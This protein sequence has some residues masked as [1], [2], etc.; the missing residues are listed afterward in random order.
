MILTT[1]ERARKIEQEISVT[2][3]HIER[4]KRILSLASHDNKTQYE[5]KLNN[6]IFELEKRL[7]KYC[8]M[9]RDALELVN[10]LTGEERAVIERYYILAQ[11]HE[12]IA[13]DM[14]MSERTVYNVKKRALKKLSEVSNE[15]T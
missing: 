2:V 14:Y 12:R 1:L 4:L 3:A 11:P 8:D 10:R 7:D 5:D 9:K 6:L 15:Q 13:I